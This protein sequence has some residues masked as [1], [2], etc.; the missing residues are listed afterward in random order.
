MTAEQLSAERLE[1]LL[2][3][4][5]QNKWFRVRQSVYTFDHNKYENNGLVDIAQ[6]ETK[7]N[8]TLIAL[9]PYLA[10]RVL[11]AERIIRAYDELLATVEG[12]CPSLLDPCSGGSDVLCNLVLDADA[13][14]TAYREN[15]P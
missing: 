9:A 12:E 7:E 4:V 6:C 10:R 13:A 3:K 2:G 11:A 5:T 14:L 1:E 15:N 8:A